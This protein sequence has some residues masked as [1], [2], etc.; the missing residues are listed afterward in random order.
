MGK[1]NRHHSQTKA[2][3]CRGGSVV[4][5][6]RVGVFGGRGASVSDA[7]EG[8]R[9]APDNGWRADVSEMKEICAIKML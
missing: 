5:G 1:K 8:R 3:S 6:D 9:S 4:K 7:A 2:S